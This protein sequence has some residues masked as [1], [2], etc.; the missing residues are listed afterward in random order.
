MP[1]SHAW[2]TRSPGITARVDVG[3]R[4]QVHVHVERQAVVA[5]AVLDFQ[6][7]CGDLRAVDIHA[8]CFLAALSGHAVFCQQVDHCLFHQPHQF[9]HVD[10]PAAHV[11]QQVGDDLAGAVIGDLAA[12]VDLDHWNIG[13]VQ[14]VFRLAGKTLGVYGRMLH[15]PDFIACSAIPLGGEFFHRIPGRLVFDQSQRMNDRE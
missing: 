4:G 1:S 2:V 5:A 12:A 13:T 7:E 11:E 14:Q 10:L 3:E 9:A 15:Q 6:S 8:G